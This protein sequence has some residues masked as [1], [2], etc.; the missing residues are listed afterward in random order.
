MAIEIRKETGENL[1][2]FIRLLTDI[3]ETMEQ[4][5]WFFLDPPEVFRKLMDEGIMEL[6]VAMDGD[7][8]AGALDILHPGYGE[9]NYGY[10][11]GFDREQLLQVVNMDSAA[12][13]PD[14][15]G[16]GIQG[17]LLEAAEQALRGKGERYLLCTIHPENRFSLNNALK[18]GYA[19]VKT[20]PKYGSVRHFLCKKIF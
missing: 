16:L 5:D 7:R 2:G 12:V 18:Q 10:G 6:W 3:R 8:L 13:H 4:K 9:Y 15:R 19:I 11:L 17:R 1:E 14:Y 20:G